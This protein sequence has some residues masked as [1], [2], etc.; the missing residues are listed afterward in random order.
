MSLSL[1]ATGI[2]KAFAGAPALRGVDLRVEQGEFYALV[3]PSGCG[4]STLLR[5]VGGHERPDEGRI[6]IA[7]RDVT[8]DPPERRPVHTVFQHYALFPHL[9]VEDNVA[10]PLRMQGVGRRERRARATEALEMVRLPGYGRRSVATLSGGER[11]RVA[12]ARALVPRPAI[13]LLDEPLGALDLQLRRAMQDEIRDL[14][15]RVGLTFL[16][17]THDQE[18]AF[19]LADEV[20]VLHRGRVAQQGTP[21]DVYRRPATPF[22]AAFL[23]VGNLLEGRP[24]ADPRR[25]RTTQGLVLEAA[26]PVAGATVAAIREETVTVH[27]ERAGV[28]A[29]DLSGVVEDVAF[30]G[31]MTR[32]SVRVG[33]AGASVCGIAG[34]DHVF[35][36]GDRATLH[37]DP[38]DVLLLRPDAVG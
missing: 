18:E 8:D 22:V 11:Q 17:V 5:I 13:V 12:L 36:R 30:L 24:E 2:H 15:R 35:H 27:P 3:G 29:G 7:G 38:D 21:R 31:A 32:V 23:G 14:Q 20:A 37:V 28:P 16:H 6:T 25:F 9:S 26:V 4:K 34:D 10:F 19:R 1:E 33:G